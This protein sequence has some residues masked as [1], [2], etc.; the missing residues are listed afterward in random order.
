VFVGV[1]RFTLLVATSHSLK[2]KR[3]VIRRTKDRVREQ[4]GVNLSEISGHDTWQ[5][6]D[7]AFAVVS[8]ERDHAQSGC[9][10]VL[11][12]VGGVDGAQIAAA[13]I[14]VI[15]FGEDWYSDA[16]EIGRAWDAKTGAA[17]PDLSWV[18]PQWLEEGE[19]S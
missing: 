3:V 11:R 2:E 12:Q 17:P 15:P 14:E 5:R 8:R 13:K 7:L 4:L 10:G 18:P 9:E 1:C 6:A 16:A 19:D